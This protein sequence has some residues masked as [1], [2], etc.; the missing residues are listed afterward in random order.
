MAFGL[1]LCAVGSSFKIFSYISL[2]MIAIYWLNLI[3]Y[4]KTYIIKYFAFI[5]SAMGTVVGAALIE[6]MPTFYLPEL[7]CSSHFSGS[8]PL[9]IL[10]YW[11]FLFVLEIK[12][13]YYGQTLRGIRVDFSRNKKA[14]GKIN[15]L[16]ACSGCLLLVLFLYEALHFPPSIR[17]GMDRFIYRS[18][19]KLPWI[20]SRLSDMS[21]LLLLFPLLALIYANRTVA[22]ISILAYCA[23]F[24]WTGEKFGGFFSLLCFLLIF[25]YD[26]V[27]HF[28]KHKLRRIMRYIIVAFLALVLLAVFVVVKTTRSDPKDYFVTRASQ[29]GQLWWKIYD[30]YQGD[31]HPAE[32]DNE[33]RALV[34]GSKSNQESIGAQHGIY[35][36]M[37]LCA[38]ESTVTFKLGTGARYTQGDYAVVYYYFGVPGVLVYSIIM[39]LVV[40]HIVNSLIL[41]LKRR[42]YIRAFI[43]LRFFTMIRVSFSMFTF[44][45]FLD[46]LSILSYLY[47][48]YS[49]G[50][51]FR[52]R[53]VDRQM[54][55]ATSDLR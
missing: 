31:T 47:L 25:F 3:H 20:L 54:L 16:A 39:G 18:T 11:L 40:S 37:Y 24:L 8:L 2:C 17:I 38:P 52:P 5:F 50:K 27:T 36:A 21:Y 19:Y 51:K 1:M 30:L 28:G 33:I 22:V 35:K 15:L 12:D 7:K 53:L 9:L 10:S 14:K 32:F 45:G 29:Q 55:N 6:F 26:Q 43:Y 4:D 42:D 46:V 49:H 48:I 34:S 23:H 41:T 44:E 13:H